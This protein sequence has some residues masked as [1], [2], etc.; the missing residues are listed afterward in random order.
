LREVGGIAL[1]LSKPI[2]IFTGIIQN[3][4]KSE[5]KFSKILYI[6]TKKIFMLTALFLIIF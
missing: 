2:F 3:G 5:R 6:I 1:P 4:K